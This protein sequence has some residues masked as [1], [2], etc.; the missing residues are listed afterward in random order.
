LFH[1][2]AMNLGRQRTLAIHSVFGSR[3]STTN[4]TPSHAIHQTRETSIL[5]MKRKSAGQGPPGAKKAK[6]TTDFVAAATQQ[7]IPETTPLASLLN[8]LHS[9]QTRASQKIGNVVHWFRSDLRLDDNRALH[10]ASQK[11]KQNGKS[12]IAL[13]VLSPQVLYALFSS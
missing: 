12:L 4:C 11:A 6:A 9:H 8:T 5:S 1:F 13:Y 2:C 7:G 3:T 10:A